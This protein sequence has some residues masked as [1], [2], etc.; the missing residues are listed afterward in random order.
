LLI[1]QE[2]LKDL[3]TRAIRNKRYHAKKKKTKSASKAKS[4]PARGRKRE[5]VL[6]KFIIKSD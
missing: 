1:P 3:L 6:D 5:Y 2:K 4:K